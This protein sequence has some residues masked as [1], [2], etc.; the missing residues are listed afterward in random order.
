LQRTAAQFLTIAIGALS[1]LFALL[2]VFDQFWEVVYGW[3]GVGLLARL[4]DQL[5]AR[6]N[7]GEAGSASQPA[8]DETIAPETAASVLY[9]LNVFVPV[10]AMLH[11]GF[12]DGRAGVVVAAV[13]VLSAIYR[14]AFMPDRGSGH[15]VLGLPAVWA[16]V[17]FLLHAFDATPVA[18]VAGVGVVIILG[19]LPLKWPLIFDIAEWPALTPLVAGVA[20]AAAAVTLWQGFPAAPGLKTVY[21]IVAVYTIALLVRENLGFSP[22]RGED[23]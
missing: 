3:L 23:R 9:V 18:A 17:G 6:F 10:V 5:S 11:A 1:G 22:G 7:A 4:V 16:G 12:L 13:V 15:P 19:L 2:A 14:M 21:A 8:G 20:I